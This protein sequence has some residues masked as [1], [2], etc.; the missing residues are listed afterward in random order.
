MSEKT[1]L[2][3]AY[4][5]SG[6]NCAASALAAFCG[7][8]DLDAETAAKLACPLGGGMRCGEVCGALSGALLVIGLEHGQ[9]LPGDEGAKENCYAHTAEFAGAFRE[10]FGAVRC[11]DLLGVD[12]TQPGGREKA[13]DAGLFETVCEKLIEGAVTLL[14]ERGYG[15]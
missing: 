4:H 10:K 6:F 2:A 11:P 3:R 7:D 13:R 15:A 8:Y 5:E 1:E 12:T 9:Y 14:E